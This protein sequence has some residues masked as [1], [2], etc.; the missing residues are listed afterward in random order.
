MPQTLTNTITE[1]HAADAP[2]P[3][4]C[5][6]HDHVQQLRRDVVSLVAAAVADAW[7]QV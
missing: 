1:M 7:R 3:Y 5:V 6:P 2:T 4:L